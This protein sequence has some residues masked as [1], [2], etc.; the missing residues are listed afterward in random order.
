MKKTRFALLQ[1]VIA[2]L[3]CCSMLVG[4]TFAWFTDTV[5]SVE[6]HIV[7]GNLDVEL[8]WS[9]D[10]ENW[11]RVNAQTN[12][13][14]ETKWEPGHTEVVY[15]RV[16]NAG[17]LAL[18]YR[19]GINVVEEQG[20]F[21]QKGNAFALSQFIEFG[22]VTPV[23]E[24]YAGREEARA[25]LTN[26]QKIS[27]GFQTDGSLVKPGISDVLALVVYMPETVGNDANHATGMEAPWV[28]LGLNVYATQETEES[29]S[30]GNTYDSGA[31]LPVEDLH[32]S[33]A[34]PLASN[35]ISDTN[36]L[37][38][39]MTLGAEDGEIYAEVPAE[40][41]LAEGAT[42]LEFKVET[43]EESQANVTLESGEVAN[44]IDVHVE[45]VAA[46]NTTPITVTLKGLFA[47]G[48]NAGNYKMYHVENGVTVEMTCVA[49]LD[50][51]DAHNEFY[52]DV[53]TG[54]VVVAMASFSEVVA[55]YDPANLWDGSVT[56]AWYDNVI[57]NN[58]DATEFTIYS[59]SDLAGLA[60]IVDGGNTFEGKT[61]I[62]NTDINLEGYSDDANTIRISF[63]PI[64]WGYENSAWNR[65][66]AEGK[67]FKG[68]FNG[69]GK[70]IYGLYQ[71]GWALE[72]S[73]GTDYTYTN[74][75]FGLFASASTATFT[76]LTISGAT[77]I[78]ECVEAGVLVGLAQGN[79]RFENINIFGSEIA[80]YQRPA[81][82]V[83]GEV[84][85]A[86]VD[87]VAQKSTHTFKN[88]TVGTNTTVG[89]LWGDFDTPVGGVIGARWD[90]ANVTYVEMDSVNVSCKLDVYNDVTSTYQWYAYRRAGMLIG[91]TDE[92]GADGKNA[93]TA[94]ATFLNCSD[95][96][97]V[98]GDW[99][100]YHYCQ[101]TNENNPGVNWPWVRVEA[102][103]NCSAYSNPRYGQ[104]LDAAGNQV[105][106]SLHT[107]KSGDK[108]LELIPFNQL[109]GGG[110][111]VYGGGQG[112]E[113]GSH[114]IEGVTIG[115]YTV[116]YIDHGEVVEVEYVTNN[117]NEWTP[118]FPSISKVENGSTIYP[119]KWEDGNNTPYAAVDATGKIS[120]TQ[121]IAAGNTEDIIL[122]PQWAGE[123][124]IRCFDTMGD[125]VYF[126]MFKTNDT[127]THSQIA[128]EVNEV[129]NNIQEEVDS[130]KKVI[131]VKWNQTFDA[132]SLSSAQDDVVLKATPN[133]TGT[134]ITLTPDD[135]SNPTY[136][137]VTDVNESNSNTKIEIP[138]YVGTTPVTAIGDNAFD[139]FDHLHTVKIPATVTNIG[140]I[141]FA[142]DYSDI[143]D[144]GETIT[145][146]FEG[147]K[148]KWNLINKR[149]LQVQVGHPHE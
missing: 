33:V 17:N 32:F 134:S 71:S 119:Q 72:E 114:P 75:G 37:T 121:T 7:A 97:V 79:C 38:Q 4:T 1:S 8:E 48:L 15:L 41:K 76:D 12:I 18:Q 77:V 22:T 14:A 50:E 46:D 51:L 90:D 23:T 111:G 147:S 55:T 6:N 30:F 31:T 61:I 2:L 125:L 91:N 21:N 106:D 9:T 84:S 144:D 127:T 47:A 93:K 126:K 59:A 86:Y 78:V 5:S 88:V 34:L 100:N 68:T 24:K 117:A 87:G 96:V 13:F 81:G 16:V 103:E 135:E 66:G 27:A 20:S 142:E 10:F 29:D 83:V 74:C 40:V 99:V 36:T 65:D 105:Q 44:S 70:T 112:T 43:I 102:G 131:E 133:L 82:G 120:P 57:S 118:S 109:Y 60:E 63:D 123:Y 94:T 11:S 28:K 101:F 85:P 49:T 104:P 89:S 56:T 148:E 130:N 140:S 73:T 113:I 108:C 132:N 42:A 53:A 124:A 35:M 92:P 145:I 116:S 54:D 80:N 149:K 98:Y 3:L 143:A 45:G 67:P 141:A 146:Y 128:A 122:Y 95:C 136:Y 139:Q 64:G 39:P 25:A 138:A 110:Q 107:H 137:T 58:S 52:Y 115:A 129:L 19:L 69:N 26:A 62:L